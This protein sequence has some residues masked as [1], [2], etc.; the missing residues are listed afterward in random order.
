[1][2]VTSTDNP[3]SL[4]YGLANGS[5]KALE[6]DEAIAANKTLA[7]Q[8]QSRLKD[9]WLLN[10][11][12][13]LWGAKSARAL[14]AYKHFQNL[15]EPG[16]NPHIAASL[17]NTKPTDL[18]PG[19]QLNGDW[20][21]RTVMWINLHNQQIS[22]NGNKGEI[23]IV[24]FRGLDRNGKWNGNA[25]FIWNDRRC[26]LVI[27][28][29]AP[30]FAGNW[31]ATCDPG[32]YYWD[33]PMNQEGCADIKAWQY[34]A[35]SVGHHHGSTGDQLALVQTGDITVLRGSDRLPDEG[36][37]FS[38]DQHTTNNPDGASPDEPVK[39]WSAG[40]MVGA[41][42]NEH[43]YEFMSLVQADP[44]EKNAPGKYQH[45]TTVINGNEFLDIFPG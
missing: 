22:T 9:F 37:N 36:N 4:L 39:G 17:L 26:V 34:Q 25:P 31:L 32:E 16:I 35:W 2:P 42:S 8:L 20:P 3:H 30:T 33:N 43:Y 6:D 28:D 29:K 19:F 10:S 27:K 45:W 41:S 15:S 13:G 7:L 24:Y 38:V 5:V 23:N 18:I 44:R 1:M 11:P 12:D 40:C 14:N 21:S